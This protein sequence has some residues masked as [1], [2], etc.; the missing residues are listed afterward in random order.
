MFRKKITVSVVGVFHPGDAKQVR[1]PLRDRNNPDFLGQVP[2]KGEDGSHSP[3]ATEDG[4]LKFQAAC[5]AIGKALAE[6]GHPIL[7][8]VPDWNAYNEAEEKPEGFP[9]ADFVVAGAQEAWHWRRSEITLYRPE[10][11]VPDGLDKAQTA[12]IPHTI[13]NPRALQGVNLHPKFLPSVEGRFYPQSFP[14]VKDADA[15]ILI[16]GERIHQFVACVAH[17]VQGEPVVAIPSFGGVAKSLYENLF[18]EHY[19]D[20]ATSDPEIRDELSV[21]EGAWSKG[22][23][24]SLGTGGSK[25]QNNDPVAKQIL[26]MD[27]A[28]RARR[29][30]RLTERLYNASKKQRER[31][32][33]NRSRLAQACIGGFLVWVFLF[34][35]L[36]AAGV[37]VGESSITHFW[38]NV[39]FWL[40]PLLAAALGMML[41][42]IL[43]YRSTEITRLDPTIL[44]T[45]IAAAILLAVGFCLIYLIGGWSFKGEAVALELGENT[46]L[47]IAGLSLIGL[48]AGLLLPVEEL[49]THLRQYL[50]FD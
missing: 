47:T 8:C 41:R 24:N 38:A 1:P 32:S 4:L 49:S 3:P 28:E 43:A 5:R 10:A 48:A 19:E 37:L 12:I 29:I 20:L 21:L 17:H 30:V 42:T 2:C 11:A 6:S 23:A 13:N 31:E 15:I 26:P 27:N 34:A 16:S 50:P 45:D 7:L 44:V 14:S 39:L 33:R 35:W 40:P 18:R 46:A 22:S 25:A 36:G 9:V